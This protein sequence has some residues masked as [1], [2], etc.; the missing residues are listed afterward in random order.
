MRHTRDRYLIAIRCVL[1]HLDY[2]LDTCRERYRVSTLYLLNYAVTIAGTLDL[3]N[4]R[5][6]RLART[7]L[8]N[9]MA[10]LADLDAFGLV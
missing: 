6:T 1:L 3:Q 5:G 2:A 4:E 9:S 7:L 8:G 10:A